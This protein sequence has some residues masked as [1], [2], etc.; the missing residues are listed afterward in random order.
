MYL[1][2]IFEKEPPV[3]IFPKHHP[4]A[5]LHPGNP[6]ASIV[7]CVRHLFVNPDDADADSDAEMLTDRWSD[8]LVLN[9]GVL[10]HFTT[11][12]CDLKNLVKELNRAFSFRKISTSA[13]CD[14]F[15]DLSHFFNSMYNKKN[16]FQQ[17]NMRKICS[18]QCIFPD[19]ARFPELLHFYCAAIP[20]FLVSWR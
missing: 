5:L 6:G 17:K 12:S 10:K 9:E 2:L 1:F 14:H 11:H 7:L 15:D 19:Q 3:S 8:D 20:L 13:S 18:H 4:K 16:K